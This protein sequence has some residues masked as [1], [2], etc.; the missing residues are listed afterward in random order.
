SHDNIWKDN[1]WLN[2]KYRSDSLPDGMTGTYVM[3]HLSN[4]HVCP[5]TENIYNALVRL[6]KG[7]EMLLQG[8]LVRAQAADGRVM[9][10]S[11]TRDD[12]EGGACECF[13]VERL[14]VE[15]KVYE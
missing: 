15:D 11:L 4:N 2:V 7:Q 10:S 8:Y 5:A 13:Y 14:Q 9:S 12:D 1:Q 6:K 3:S